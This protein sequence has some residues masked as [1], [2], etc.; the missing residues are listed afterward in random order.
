MTIQQVAALAGVSTATV[1]R[2]LAGKT[3]VS[4]ATKLRVESAAKELGYVVS[5]SASSL[6]SGRTRNIGVVMPFLD[7]WFYTRVLKGAHEALSDA[8]YDLTLYHLDQ[9]V[10]AP[11]APANPRRARLF[12]E[13]LRRQRVDG[14]IAVSLELSDAELAGLE[15]IGKPAVGIGGPIPGALTLSIDDAA[16]ARLATDHLLSLGHRQIAHIGG[17]PALDLDF[18]LPAH[19]RDGY[20][21]ALRARGLEPD[22]LMVRVADFT[23]TG[24]YRATLQ[25]LGDPRVAPTAL[26]A[27]SDEM[28]MGAIM[29]A[30]DL[31]KR[32]PQ[33]LSIIGIDG[34]ELGEFFGLTTVSQFP[35][36][37]GRLAAEAV[38]RALDSEPSVA[39]NVALPF[40]LVVRRSTS[41][42]TEQ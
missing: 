42:P 17:D 2:A 13:F 32:V 15:A 7:G 8:G 26:F 4:A 24:G 9:S 41:V 21:S 22:P 19:R 18:H 37:Q 38:L 5:S 35:E 23:I 11:G 3:T 1:S 33:D 10:A 27:A 39:H 36:T 16:V 30:R 6:A 29:A 31:G 14:F 12:D 34:H 28:A 20:E 25:L 40:E